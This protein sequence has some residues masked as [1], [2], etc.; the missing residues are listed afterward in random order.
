VV[1]T[2]PSLTTADGPDVIFD[3]TSHFVATYDGTF[4]RLFVNGAQA[5]TQATDYQAST[6]SRLL[7]GAGGP[8]LPEPRV[9]WVGKIQCVAV[10]K[11]ALSPEEVAK[12]T[13]YGNGGDAS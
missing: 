6:Q 3:A 13:V 7:I 1:G 5:T 2:G 12:H 11:G 4:F 9:P 8:Q 10:Y